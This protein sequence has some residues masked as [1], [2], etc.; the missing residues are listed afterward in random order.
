MRHFRMGFARRGSDRDKKAVGVI[1]QRG[2][3]APLVGRKFA[4]GARRRV[5]WP[6]SRTAAAARVPAAREFPGTRSRDL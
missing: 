5:G 6:S 3:E 2:N 1:G 4:T